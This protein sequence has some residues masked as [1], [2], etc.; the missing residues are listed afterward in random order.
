M[1][2]QYGSV[3]SHRRQSHKEILFR[4]NGGTFVNVIEVGAVIVYGTRVVKATLALAAVVIVNVHEVSGASAVS[5]A[6]LFTGMYRG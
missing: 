6:L 4:F 2:L 5:A 1:K 3:S